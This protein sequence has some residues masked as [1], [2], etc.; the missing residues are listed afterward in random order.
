MTKDVDF[1]FCRKMHHIPCRAFIILILAGL[2]IG[3]SRHARQWDAGQ[4][5]GRAIPAFIPMAAG[6]IDL[7]L[8][9]RVAD[10]VAWHSLVLWTP[11]SGIR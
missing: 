3:D 4:A 8:Y 2:L 11:I 7:L 9:E 1:F 5:E 10:D 6:A